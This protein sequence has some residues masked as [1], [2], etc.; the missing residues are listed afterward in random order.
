MVKQSMNLSEPNDKWLA[1]KVAS[2]EYTSKTDVVN[3]LCRRAREREDSTKSLE[4]LI[5][6]GLESGISTRTAEDIRSGV[7]KR[8]RKNS[9]L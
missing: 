8:L 5:A 7:Q 9:Q 6:E 1:D 4:I 2:K 3:D